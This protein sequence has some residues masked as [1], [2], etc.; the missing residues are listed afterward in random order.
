LLLWLIYLY[1]Y[2]LKLKSPSGSY[3]AYVTSDNQLG[4]IDTKTFRV[5]LKI[6]TA[7]LTNNDDIITSI[8][9]TKEEHE[10]IIGTDQ[11]VCK[12]LILQRTTESIGK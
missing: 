8:S 4:V 11:G 5:I 12:L 7:E 1:N 9:Y 2:Y 6:N 10:L 3:L